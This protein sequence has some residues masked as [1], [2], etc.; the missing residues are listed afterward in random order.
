MAEETANGL[1]DDDDDDDSDDDQVLS[2]LAHQN[3]RPKRNY[4]KYSNR[5]SLS[6]ITIY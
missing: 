6:S 3:S 1:E 5:H 2:Q 4:R